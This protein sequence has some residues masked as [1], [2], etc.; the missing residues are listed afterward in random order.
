MVLN[1]LEQFFEPIE[2]PPSPR[3]MGFS[4]PSPGERGGGV[5]QT[6]GG[7]KLDGFVLSVDQQVAGRQQVVAPDLDLSLG[8]G[9]ALD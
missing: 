9:L 1:E 5:D 8:L 7:S 2:A 3:G 4:D 6:D